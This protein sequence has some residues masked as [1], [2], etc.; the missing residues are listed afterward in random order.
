M[1]AKH[2]LGFSDQS[3]GFCDAFAQSL[4]TR[5]DLAG[6]LLPTLGSLLL[7]GHP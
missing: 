3:L 1:T 4:L 2:L 7:V 6:L 5:L